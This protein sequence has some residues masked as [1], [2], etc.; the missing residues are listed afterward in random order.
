MQNV[1]RGIL[2]AAA[3]PG[4]SEYA[5][6]RPNAGLKPA[7]A[8]IGCPT[9]QHS[10]NQRLEWTRRRW[11][12]RGSAAGQGARPTKSSRAATNCAECNT[13]L[14]HGFVVLAIGMGCVLCAA[15]AF[16]AR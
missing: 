3:F 7:A 9:K 16:R 10:R 15:E 13:N 6:S 8:R 4:G 2:P 12:T 11:P 5:L 1:A 14:R